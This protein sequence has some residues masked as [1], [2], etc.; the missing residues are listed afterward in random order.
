MKLKH[1]VNR[2][3]VD[4]KSVV[5]IDDSIVGGTTSVKIV[6]LMREAGASEVH[7]KIASPPI[8]F[9]DFYGID[10]PNPSQLLASLRS[11]DEM[12]KFIGAD[13]WRFCL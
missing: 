4:E 11:I 9:P 3:A 8:K 1:N 2:Q 12:K 13:G 5:L 10:T 7:M 6:E